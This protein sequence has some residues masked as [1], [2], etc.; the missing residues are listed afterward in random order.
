MR[1]ISKIEHWE[2]LENI[3][4]IIDISQGVM[5]ARGDLAVEIPMEQVPKYQKQIIK[6]CN[7]LGKP[8][9]ELKVI[10]VALPL[11]PLASLAKAP[12]NVIPV[13]VGEIVFIAANP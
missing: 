12:S 13:G 10:V 4:E 1:V 5:V 2:A 3:D 7:E 6:H 9:I 11:L 8:V